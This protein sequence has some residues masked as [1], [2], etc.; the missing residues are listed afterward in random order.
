[1]ARTNDSLA[2]KISLG[3][4]TFRG[5]LTFGRKG[6]II[7]DSYEMWVM[8]IL[9]LP[10]MQM[11]FFAFLAGYLNYGTSYV[12]YVV[13]GNALQVMS[14]SAVFAVANITSQDKWQGTLPSL[15]VTPA[16]RMALLVGRAF[17]Q[18]LMS[19]LIAVTG[20][21]Y[22]GLVFGVSFSSANFV[23]IAIAIV[24]TS[25]AM[26]SFGL[27]ISAIGLYMRTAMIVANIFLFLTL[28]VS[29]VNFPV[30]TLPL[31]LQPVSYAIPMTYGVEALRMA[32]S[33]GSLLSMLLVLVQELV[34]GL[35]VLF[36]GYLLLIG[37]ERLAR[38]TGRLE[39]Y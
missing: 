1:M 36:I 32:V 4:K 29:G 13:V 33:G 14:F 6:T 26:I 34:N 35:V 12:Q 38:S 17:F 21:I 39:E 3:L 24:L 15:I 19:T 20:L 8:E 10:L 27:L 2:R 5:S 18:V 22:A 23:G 7:W 16:N 30:S 31:W 28:L 37:F 11:A 9:I 25:L